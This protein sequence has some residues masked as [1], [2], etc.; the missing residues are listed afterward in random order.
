LHGF[1]SPLADGQK[2]NLVNQDFQK[3]N[4]QMN[5]L[6]SQ[7][8][9]IYVFKCV[10]KTRKVIPVIPAVVAIAADLTA[11][12]LVLAVSAVAAVSE[13]SIFGL[14]YNMLETYSAENLNVALL[15]ASITWGNDSFTNKC[16]TSFVK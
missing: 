11:T 1:E 4:D 8:R 7:F 6:G 16:L 13:Q 2:I 3:L 12:L 14:H 15:D 5:H 10:P 9:Y